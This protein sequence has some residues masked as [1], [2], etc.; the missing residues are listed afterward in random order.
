MKF[1]ISYKYI[2]ILVLII[3]FIPFMFLSPAVEKSEAAAVSWNGDGDGSTWEDGDNWN[4]D[5]QPGAD[6]DVTIDLS[7]TVNING[8][9]TIN[10]LTL[11]GSNSPTLNFDYDAITD[12]A[13][14]IDDGD[15]TINSGA[16]I[17]HTAGTST[18]GGTI[19]IDIQSGDADIVGTINVDEKGYASSEGTGQGGNSSSGS[20]GAGYGGEGGEGVGSGGVTYGSITA[21]EDLGSGGGK[22]WTAGGAGGGAVKLNISSGTIDIDG[23]ITSNGGDAAYDRDGGG[24]GGSIY[25]IT[26]VLD[27]TGSV[28]SNGG[29]GSTKY[30]SAGGG[31][32]RVSLVYKTDSSSLT[33]T[34]YGKIGK[35]YR[36]GGAGTIYKKDTDDTYGDLIV[37]NNDLNWS[38]DFYYGR[39]PL[40]SGVTYDDITISNYGNLEITATSN[41]TYSSL[42]WNNE[43]IITDSGGTFSIVSG[44]GSITVPSTA[45]LFANT[46]R[47][48]SSMS[49]NGTVTHSNNET[50]ETYKIDVTVSGNLTVSGTGE[51]NV[52]ERGYIY[53]EGTG[54][55]SGSSSGSGG[56]GYGGEGGSSAVSG[57]VT[58]GSVTAP[59]DLGSG[60]GKGWTAGGSG[61]G[62]IKLNVTGTTNIGGT[63]SS[64]GGDYGEV[65]KDGGGSGGSI[66]ITTGTLSGSGTITADGGQGGDKSGGG[67]GGRIAMIYTTDSS[68]LTLT[69]YG[70]TGMTDRFGGAGTIYTKDTGESYGDLLIDNNDEN[71]T[72]DIYYGRTPLGSGLTYDEITVSNYGDLE[73]TGTCNATYSTLTWSNEGIITDSGGTFSIVSGGGSITVPSTAILFANTT[74]T[75]SS[76]SINGTVTHSNNE[77]SETYKID[78]TV[79]GN[80]TVSGTGEINVDEK[81]YI[82]EQG[83]GAGGGN[84]SG[85]GGGGYGGVGGDG[86]GASGGITYGSETAPNNIGSGGG[87][88]WSAGGSGGGA[89]ILSVTGTTDVDGSISSIGG[90]YSDRKDGGGSGGSI[91][92]TTGTID[93]TGTIEAGGG[94]GGSQSGGGGGGRIAIIYTTNNWAGN[95]LSSAV[96]TPGGTGG[97]DNGDNGTVYLA[98]SNSPPVASSVSIDS[99][100]SDIDLTENTTTEVVCAAT[101]T[102]TDGYVD[103]LSVEAKLYRTSVGHSASDDNNNHYTLSG[104]TECVPSNG[105]GD[106]EDYTCTFDVYFHADPTDSGSIYETDDWTCRVMPSDSDGE[107][108]ADTDTIEI[109]TLIALS[110]SSSIDYGNLQQGEDTGSSNQTTVVTNTGNAIIDLEVSGNGSSMCTDFPTCS[111]DVLGVTNQEYSLSTFS[112]GSGSDLSTTPAT[113]DI[114]IPKPTTSPS[115]Q[116]DNMYWGI[117]IPSMQSGGLYEGENIFTALDNS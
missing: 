104:D 10:S 107:G 33:V 88:G 4:S 77:T 53:E 31:G 109:N 116:E 66:Y 100:A 75:F 59:E 67:G 8:S 15:L 93:G 63:I 42:T 103:I 99:G 95:T 43:G 114:T 35:T 84:Y 37:D 94:T 36:F 29:L 30:E 74:R 3:F 14:I 19:Y 92:I 85:S 89:I 55:G 24:S 9:T 25:I 62:A 27:G 16:D 54:A 56:A 47:T 72:T 115:N 112:Y 106:T 45:I 52:D 81:G 60:G 22:G 91:Y 80:L 38:T 6:D 110:V 20:G 65:H 58:Y 50:S 64:D 32:G 71:G 102:D 5:S 70:G 7:V 26:N 113:I 111:G 105:G 34:A 21:P 98:G 97:N 41:E 86:G 12:G 39:T 46:T 82:S 49:I 69:A 76:M 79:S 117:G 96:A 48:F 78:V 51:I 23:S 2:A 87:E 11:G 44:G 90:D 28:T 73:I 108:T 61:G 101:V 83:I 68:S 18:V 57:G 17:T 40:G 1:K 13:L